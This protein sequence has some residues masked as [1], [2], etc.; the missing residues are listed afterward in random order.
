[1]TPVFREARAAP[2]A[3]VDTELSIQ[4]DFFDGVSR[5]RRNGEFRLDFDGTGEQGLSEL[6]AKL[7]KILD[8]S[9]GHRGV[10]RDEV[11]LLFGHA[12]DAAFGDD[13]R[14]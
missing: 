13:E 6:M 9:V 3:I 1:M 14:L 2:F 8:T 4:N 10:D 5:S 7:E 12:H 11:A